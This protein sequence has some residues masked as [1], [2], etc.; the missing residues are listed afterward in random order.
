[1]HWDEQSKSKG[2]RQSKTKARDSNFSKK[3]TARKRRLRAQ[4]AAPFVESSPK[5]ENTRPAREAANRHRVFI[6]SAGRIE[7]LEQQGI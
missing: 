1:M 5:Y 7:S 6:G 3:G 2:K 4:E